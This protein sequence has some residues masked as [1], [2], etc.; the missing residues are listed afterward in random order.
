LAAGAAHVADHAPGLS[1]R[2]SGISV[3]PPTPTDLPRAY[4]PAPAVP[5]AHAQPPEP[6]PLPPLALPVCFSLQPKLQ[7]PRAPKLFLVHTSNPPSRL[8][9][10]P[11]STIAG[12]RAPAAAAG[13]PPLN[14]PLR[15]SS[16]P[17]LPVQQVVE[18]SP[19]PHHRPS[20][21]GR[22]AAA[23]PPP[24][25]G[26][27]S[28]RTTATNQS[29]VSP[30]NDPHNMFTF[31][32]PTSPL[33]SSPPPSGPRGESQGYFYEDLKSSRDCSVKRFFS[34]LCFGSAPCKIDYKL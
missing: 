1:T 7:L 5:R 17:R 11:S 26:D 29:L 15:R 16:E 3:T 12:A 21:H 28:G 33:A 19:S 18:P 9:I 25:A 34:V 20:S 4:K 14:S 27:Y 10:K 23:P 6:P 24:L 31:P 32:C 2:A 8:L 30:V 13:P 22:A